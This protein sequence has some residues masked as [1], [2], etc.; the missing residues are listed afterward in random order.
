MPEYRKKVDIQASYHLVRMTG[1]EP[2]HLTAL[3]PNG[4]VTMLE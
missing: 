1:L 2:A 4:S 3:E